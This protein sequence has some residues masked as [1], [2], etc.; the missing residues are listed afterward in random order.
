M[1]SGKIHL[2]VWFLAMSMLMAG[3]ATKP[4]TDINKRIMSLEMVSKKPPDAT[5][6]V[7]PPDSIQVEFVNQ[8]ELTTVQ[9]IR[10]DG[11]VMLPHLGETKVAGMTPDQ[12]EDKLEKLYVKYYETPQFIVTVTAYLSKHY[13]IYGEVRGQGQQPYTGYQTVSDAIGAAGGVTSRAATKRVRVIRGDPY[14]PEVYKIDLRALLY[15]GDTRQDVSLAENDVIY[16]PP[17]VLAWV[18]YRIDELLFPFRSILGIFSTA[19]AVGD[20]GN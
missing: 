2:V 7:D 10:Q 19:E 13:S 14:D 9:R 17:T 3:C 6:I 15:E 1:E 8:P 11:T 20:V 16:V 5:Y 12:I 4:I 18:G